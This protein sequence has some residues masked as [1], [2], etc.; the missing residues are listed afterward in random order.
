[1]SSTIKRRCYETGQ[2]VNF[3]TERGV[4]FTRPKKARGWEGKKKNGKRKKKK[5][6]VEKHEHTTKYKY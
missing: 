4:E 3:D 6:N 1:M 2:T 5:E